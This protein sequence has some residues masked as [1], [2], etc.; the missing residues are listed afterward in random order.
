MFWE[1]R[2][3]Q[4]KAFRVR[5][6]SAPAPPVRWGGA[7]RAGALPR[8][9]APAPAEVALGVPGGD[10]CTAPPAPQPLS[11]AGQEPRSPWPAAPLRQ[12]PPG[13]GPTCARGSPLA[14]SLAQLLPSP[15]GPEPAPAPWEPL[16]DRP[17]GFPRFSGR[18]AGEGPCPGPAGH[19]AAAPPP[20]PR[21]GT[22]R[23]LLVPARD[24]ALRLQGAPEPAPGEGWGEALAIAGTSLLSLF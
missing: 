6:G 8:P 9:P 5:P 24:A 1:G 14:R 23:P 4:E 20:P 19:S 16:P 15:A 11:P 18:G 13:P 21:S 12:E 22:L 10:G 3:K 17:D 7:G 2:R